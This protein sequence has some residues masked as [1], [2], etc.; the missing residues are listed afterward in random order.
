MVK[1]HVINIGWDRV[2]TAMH[3]INNFVIVFYIEKGEK[4]MQTY[5]TS[6]MVVAIFYGL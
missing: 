1:Q 5:Y 4:I 3:L 2:I 6:P